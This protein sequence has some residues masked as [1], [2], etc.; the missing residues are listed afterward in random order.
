MRLHEDEH[1]YHV[2]QKCNY[3]ASK[4]KKPMPIFWDLY[5]KLL[6]KQIQQKDLHV[7]SSPYSPFL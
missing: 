7:V 4:K 5:T 1:D 3:T 6:R 2:C